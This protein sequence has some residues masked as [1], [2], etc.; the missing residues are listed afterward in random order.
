VRPT[1]NALRVKLAFSLKVFA[2][3]GSASDA[4]A[5][6]TALFETAKVK[7]HPECANKASA[8]SI[9]LVAA[10]PMVIAAARTAA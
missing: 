9:S 7:V 4:A 5:A 1:T 10:K 8:E 3:S 6:T 2:V